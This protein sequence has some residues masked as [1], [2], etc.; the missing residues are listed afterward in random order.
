M[1]V[2]CR[3]VLGCVSGVMR[4]E[5]RC[6]LTCVQTRVDGKGENWII[7][8][9]ELWKIKE[10]MPKITEIGRIMM[11]SILLLL[12]I[13]EKKKEECGTIG[14]RVIHVWEEL[15]YSNLDSFGQE[16]N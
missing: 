12:I 5:F 3:Q 2:E 7:E 9:N 14:I 11:P 1:A 15:I 6:K 10:S 16:N 13:I 4:H 8:L